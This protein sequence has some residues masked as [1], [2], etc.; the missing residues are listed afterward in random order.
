MVNISNCT[1]YV[2]KIGSFAIC[3][4]NIAVITDYTKAF[5]KSPITFKEGVYISI[6]DNNGDLY[7]TNR[8]AVVGWYNPATQTFEV[9]N[10]NAGFTVLLIGRI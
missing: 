4:M 7:T 5:I 1:S 3:S 2:I 9:T 10:I 6:E 8:Q